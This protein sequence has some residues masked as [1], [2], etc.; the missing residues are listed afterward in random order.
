MSFGLE[1]SETESHLLKS[2]YDSVCSGIVDLLNAAR[3]ATARSVNALMTAT[4]WEIG[5]RI[6]D[7]EM[8]GDRR[9][10]YGAQLVERLAMDLTKQFGRGFGSASLWRM[11]GF[12]QAWPDK[13]IL[14]TPLREFDNLANAASLH[15][16][17]ASLAVQFP[18]PWSAYLRLLA[19]KKPEARRFYE[20]EALRA[21]WSVRQLDR[22]IGS[23]F[24]ER[25]ALS[26][27]KAA[28]LQ[29]AERPQ[30]DDVITP[31]EAIKDP[32]V[33]EFLNLKDEYSEPELEEALI[34]HLADFLLE[35]G[36]DFA[37]L[38]RQR[39]LRLD[40]SWFRI[41]LVFFHRLA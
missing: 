25:I 3:F 30:P 28:M 32:F 5:R 9:A 11:R 24:Y 22:Q 16:D 12:Y 19:V 27:N 17:A 23:Q 14:A 39:R 34:Q 4:Y 18:L 1:M 15:S 26:R 35:L 6:V 33:L 31:E 2:E 21:G 40:D 41:D 38:G 20:S 29:K 8:R 7:S 36:D 37:L 13:N 10:E